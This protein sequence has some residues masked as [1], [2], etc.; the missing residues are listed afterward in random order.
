MFATCI[1]ETTEL[2]AIEN[3]SS[4][5]LQKCQHQCANLLCACVRCK[6]S[7]I[8]HMDLYTCNIFPIRLSTCRDKEE[9][10]LPPRHLCRDLSLGETLMNSRIQCD[11]RLVILE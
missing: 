3:P 10:I 7:H 6:V 1:T 9:I 4:T 2:P 8:Q 11:I 5:L